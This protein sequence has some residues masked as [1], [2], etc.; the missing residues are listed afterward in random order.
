MDSSLAEVRVLDLTFGIAGPFCTMFLAGLGAEV[1][2]VERPV[3]GDPLRTVGPFLNDDPHPEKSG[4]FFHLNTG[5][6][7]ITLNL[8]TPEGVQIIKR[9]VADADI[10]VENFR[11]G[12]MERLG[13]GYEVLEHLKPNLIFTSV[14]N[15]GQ[16]GPYRDYKGADIVFFG[17]GGEMYS[18]GLSRSPIREANYTIQ[19]QAGNMAATATLMAFFGAMHRGIGGQ[20][21][22]IPIF[23]TAASSPDRRIQNLLGYIYM[24]NVQRRSEFS[25]MG[26]G[27]G[28][29]PC[30]DG[31]VRV[32]GATVRF[33]P[34]FAQMMGMPEL[35]KDPRFN[36]PEA[37]RD[38]EVK[39]E[40]D[41]IFVPWLVE[42]TRDEF[43]AA[44]R[45]AGVSS[46]AIY[47]PGEVMEDPH[48]ASRGFFVDVEH[49]VMG[50]LRVPGAPA[51]M[52][53]SPWKTEPPP[54]LGQHN[55]EILGKRLGYRP[56]DLV[57]MRQCGVI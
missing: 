37:A 53:E 36:S 23:E 12:T 48:W 29:Y 4:T 14:T 3:G 39:S 1:I 42:K 56:E 11:P 17:M 50:Q 49:P 10:L 2:K 28:L 45:E 13:L 25:P 38:P 57:H 40:F 27:A 34:R 52:T 15:F 7:G 47:N 24:G 19:Y 35:A 30:K 51:K 41:A 16:T 9:L 5:K 55:A 31:F 20:R 54:T 21:L 33:L 44:A 46:G 22:D 32:A 43:M 8:K 6:K 18:T 26:L